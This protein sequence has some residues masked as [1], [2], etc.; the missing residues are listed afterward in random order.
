ML[1]SRQLNRTH[2]HIIEAFIVAHLLLFATFIQAKVGPKTNDKTNKA[3]KQYRLHFALTRNVFFL[4]SNM[5]TMLKCVYPLI[6]H[7]QRATQV[8]KSVGVCFSF[9]NVHVLPLFEFPA[10]MKKKKKKNRTSQQSD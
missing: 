2:F 1:H 6:K 4:R 3:P 8:I 10:S 7:M 5:F 9:Y